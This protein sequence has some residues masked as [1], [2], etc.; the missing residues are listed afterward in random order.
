MVKFLPE[1]EPS[2]LVSFMR[3]ISTEPM[4]SEIHFAASG[5]LVRRKNLR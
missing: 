3:S 4:A 5:S 1:R 2:N